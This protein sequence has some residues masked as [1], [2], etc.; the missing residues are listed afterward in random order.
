MMLKEYKTPE[1]L[2][3]LFE[4]PFIDCAGESGSGEGEAGEDWYRP[5][6]DDE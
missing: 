1:L 6:Y 3:D 5:E 4:E 2:I